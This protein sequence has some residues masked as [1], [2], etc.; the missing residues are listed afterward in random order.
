[1]ASFQQSLHK[2]KQGDQGTM[3]AVPRT[4]GYAELCDDAPCS[5]KLQQTIL[6]ICYLGPRNSSSLAV[7][8]SFEMPI[9]LTVALK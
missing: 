6:T 7:L 3:L 1:M 4:R 8:A 2:H 5:I 9:H